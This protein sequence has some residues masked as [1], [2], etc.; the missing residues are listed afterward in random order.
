MVDAII[1]SGPRE[2]GANPIQISG[3]DGRKPQLCS[4]RGES[5]GACSYRR[6]S[7]ESRKAQESCWTPKGCSAG[8]AASGARVSL[9]LL[10]GAAL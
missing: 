4:E 5:S 6:S 3:G 8:V 1:N 7:P 2:A 9:T 10:S